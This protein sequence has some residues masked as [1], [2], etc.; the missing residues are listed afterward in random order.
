MQISG[1]FNFFFLLSLF[2]G[3]TAK[4]FRMAPPVLGLDATSVQKHAEVVQEHAEG[5]HNYDAQ[6]L[7]FVP[8]LVVFVHH[9]GVFLH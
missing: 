5:V 7:K 8:P 6:S 2:S 9:L 1:I 3:Q 4:C